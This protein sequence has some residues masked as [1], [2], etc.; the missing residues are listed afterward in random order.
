MVATAFHELAGSGASHHSIDQANSATRYFLCKWSD[1]TTFIEELA[2]LQHP[3]W[4]PECA[5][6][7]IA[8][9][10]FSP[11]QPPSVVVNDPTTDDVS[12]LQ[13]AEF[14]C[15]I[16]AQYNTDFSLAPWPC[17]IDKP[18]IPAGTELVMRTRASSQ[19]IRIPPRK[20]LSADNPNKNP[21]GYVPE[22]DG[23]EGRIILPTTEF[24]LQWYYVD[25][26]PIATWEEDYVG[27]V[28]ESTFL[29]AEAETLLFVG[30]DIEPSTQFLISDPFCFTV[31]CHFRKRRIV[32]GS[33]IYGWNHEFELQGWTRVQMRDGNN[34][35]VDRYQKVD[36]ADMFVEACCSSSSSSGS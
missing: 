7:S 17:D 13:N 16:T 28:N 1:R 35:A 20:F 22:P 19:V 26:P 14:N 8:V 23:Q 4:G 21:A 27:R 32:D 34:S 33:D 9:E 12:Y 6:N 24:Q 2:T 31:T 25:E 5:I 3:E 11:Q 18:T 15:L 36:F 10:P 30:F 29:G